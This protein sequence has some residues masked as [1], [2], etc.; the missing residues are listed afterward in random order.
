[1]A[2]AA[3][4]PQKTHRQVF[5]ETYEVNLDACVETLSKNG[6][7]AEAARRLC[8]CMLEAAFELDS[9]YVVMPTEAMHSFLNDNRAKLLE[10]CVECDT[11]DDTTDDAAAP[12]TDDATDDTAQRYPE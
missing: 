6:H 5:E 4:L 8:D 10:R 11:T 9:T 3:C 1:M 2:F 7:E 12:T